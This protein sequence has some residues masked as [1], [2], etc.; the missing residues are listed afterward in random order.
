MANGGRSSSSKSSYRLDGKDYPIIGSAEFDSVAAK[1]VDESTIEGTLK[2]AG[3]ATATT[4][5]AL[6]QDKKTMTVTT[7]GTNRDGQA[8]HN[9]LVFERQ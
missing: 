9:V 3:K 7:K 4:T 8:M 6:S 1:Q 2:R 5:R